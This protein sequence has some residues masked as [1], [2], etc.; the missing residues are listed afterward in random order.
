M[1]KSF[2]GMLGVVA[3]LVLF[4]SPAR[5]EEN[6]AVEVQIY[7]TGPAVD[8]NALRVVNAVLGQAVSKGDA[9][10]FVIYGFGFEGGYTACLEISRFKDVNA[11]ER[12]AAELKAIAP[13]PRTTAYTVRAIE[14]CKKAELE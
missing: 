14:S 13:N 5:A 9:Q 10:K 3:A 8:G 1:K 12:L 4:V 7:G 6:R 11:V 2:I